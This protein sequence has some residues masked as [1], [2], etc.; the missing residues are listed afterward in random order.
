LRYVPE[1]GL[2]MLEGIGVFNF[3]AG[4][5]S[6]LQTGKSQIMNDLLFPTADFHHEAFE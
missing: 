6:I 2:N 5:K 3:G 1:I 4:K